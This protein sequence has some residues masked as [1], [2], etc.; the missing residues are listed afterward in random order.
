MDTIELPVGDY[1]FSARAAGPE[2]GRL[3]V[4]LHGF[5]QSSYQWR[6]QLAALA[7][8]GYR[9][10]APDQRGYSPGARPEG[11]EHYGTDHL[12]ADVLAMVDEMGA[13]QVD[14]VGHDW[15]A[16]VAWHL[17]ARYPERLRSLTAVSLPHPVAFV[18]AALRGKGDQAVR[19]AYIG[20]F[21]QEGIAER[22]LLVN[23]G[24]GLRKALVA[25]GLPR[26]EADYYVGLMRQP[27]AL[28]AALS[29]YRAVSP[30]DAEGIGPI[31][32]P[33]L[34]VWS[35]QD[36]ALGRDAAEATASH[37]EGPYRFEVM[38]GVSHWIPEVAAEELDRLLLEHLSSWN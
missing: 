28:T 6:H 15:G 27:G 17:A 4:L 22:T 31:T 10:V 37:V 32:T 7:E 19:S 1:T 8:A 12:V 2:D 14:M 36:A 13:H 5:P 11:V 25:A 30:E 9:A 35:D 3:V 38:E 26:K 24:D 18:D 21:R 29:W 16:W 23:D 33:T 20:L 34:Y